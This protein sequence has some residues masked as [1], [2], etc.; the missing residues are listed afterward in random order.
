MINAHGYA[1]L[2]TNGENIT[3]IVLVSACVTLVIFAFLWLSH[4][5][6]CIKYFQKIDPKVTDK[7]KVISID[8][9]NPLNNVP[10]TIK[11]WNQHHARKLAKFTD[12]PGHEARPNRNIQ[13]VAISEKKKRRKKQFCDQK[14]QRLSRRISRI[15]Q[16]KVA[17][18]AIDNLCK[19]SKGP[20]T[21]SSPKIENNK[22]VFQDDEFSISETLTSPKTSM[23]VSKQK[24]DDMINNKVK[25]KNSG[26][27]L[28]AKRNNSLE[29][30]EKELSLIRQR[31]EERFELENLDKDDKR[32]IDLEKT[33]AII[34]PNAWH[35]TYDATVKKTV[36][37]CHRT[38]S[39]RLSAPK[40]WVKARR[41]SIEK[42]QL[43]GV[44]A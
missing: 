15:K 31:L 41:A 7:P 39:I 30:Y 24:K 32:R 25:L 33:A 26:R 6:R 22:A 23:I 2:R 38:K 12:V 5:W 27:Q 29:N 42:T 18:S 14:Q 4:K 21:S 9:I 34:G 3:I 13:A 37:W 11:V 44:D 8:T 20:L 36:F 35:C 43:K 16:L 10:T 1:H 17:D 40:G 19:G 28:I